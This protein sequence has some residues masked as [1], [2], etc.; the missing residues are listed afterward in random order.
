MIL[1]TATEMAGRSETDVTA[2]AD[3]SL[4]EIKSIGAE[5]GIEPS[6][7]DR[8]AR[9]IPRRRA[10]SAFERVIG[11]PLHYRVE[12]RFPEVLT[13]E[14][15]TRILSAVRAETGRPGQGEADA[16]GISWH[17]EPGASRLSVTAH[18]DPEGTDVRVAVD[19]TSM[20]LPFTVMASLLIVGWFFF[21]AE[22]VASLGDLFV[23]LGTPAAG[24]AV[25]RALWASSTRRLEERAT[26]LLD[27]VGRSFAASAGEFDEERTLPVED[28]PSDGME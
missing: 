23:L 3:L 18:S 21:F 9:L 17:S 8:A 22:D 26:G 5:V 7:I 27:V 19:R 4:A 12:T 11:G 28:T 1:R 10:E 6:L 24:L 13:E 20:F 15:A 25:S 16:A 14:S 2:D